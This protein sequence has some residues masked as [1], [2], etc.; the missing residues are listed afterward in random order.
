MLRGRKQSIMHQLIRGRLTNAQ[1][2]HCIHCRGEQQPA[3]EDDFPRRLPYGLDILGES[4]L[5]EKL[6]DTH[7]DDSL[8]ADEGILIESLSIEKNLP[9]MS[10]ST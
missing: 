8:Q 6:A 2:R 4:R 7:D 3:V 9:E 5:A 10:M 1:A